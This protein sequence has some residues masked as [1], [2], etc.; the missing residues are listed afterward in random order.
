MK[1]LHYTTSI[2]PL[3]MLQVV[4]SLD[5]RYVIQ[6]TGEQVINE[7][8]VKV[9]KQLIVILEAPIT[10]GNIISAIVDAKYSHDD[11]TAITLNYLLVL[12]NEADEDKNEEY[13]NE[14]NLLQ[15]W[16]KKAK[17]IAKEVLM[18]KII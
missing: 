4:D 11:V 3:P 16:R 7:I 10:Y 17:E 14:Y 12:H 9:W 6:D 8:G 5:N 1:E 2:L 15:N 18:H 13:M